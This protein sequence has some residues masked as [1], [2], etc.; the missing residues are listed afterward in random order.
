M[1]DFGNPYDN[2][3][4]NYKYMTEYDEQPS[5]TSTLNNKKTDI[6]SQIELELLKEDLKKSK[7]IIKEL[8]RQ[9]QLIKQAENQKKNEESDKTNNS[10]S[11]TLFDISNNR[12]LLLMIFLLV[13]FCVVQQQ[14]HKSQLRDISMLFLQ[15]AGSDRAGSAATPNLTPKIVAPVDVNG[16]TLQQ[17]A[18]T[19]Q[20]LQI[21]QQIPAQQQMT[22]Q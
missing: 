13:V 21:Q 9:N 14:T 5:I 18:P 8:E 4:D 22:S 16:L 19:P 3:Y 1:E 7:Q 11:D 12:I 15:N 2:K 17:Q 20:Q 10:M 6:N